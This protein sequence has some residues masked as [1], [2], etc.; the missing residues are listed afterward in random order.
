MTGNLTP[1]VLTLYNVVRVRV[2]NPRSFADD[3]SD[4]FGNGIGP[5][6]ARLICEKLLPMM[7]R[8]RL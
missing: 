4:L 2:L 1:T 8:I 3:E 5:E 7:N 6:V